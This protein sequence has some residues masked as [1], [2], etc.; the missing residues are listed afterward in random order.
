MISATGCCT[1]RSPATERTV[2]LLRP[3]RL[4]RELRRPEVLRALSRALERDPDNLDA[5]LGSVMEHLPEKE[6][7]AT[8]LG[9]RYVLYTDGASRNNPGPSGG[10]AVLLGSD[11]SRIDQTRQYFGAN[12]TNNAAEYRALLMGLE[13]VPDDCETLVVRMDSELIIKQLQGEY[14]VRSE[15]LK[16]YY[17]QV[18]SGLENIPRVVLEAVPREKNE[19][20]DRLANRAIEEKLAR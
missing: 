20:A 17:K 4:I 7:D 2:K 8:T 9:S 18:R 10:G 5:D 13:L 15:N 6:E 16:P 14:A 19:A 11:E 12:L 1:G 3:R